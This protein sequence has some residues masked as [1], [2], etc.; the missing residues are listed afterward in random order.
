MIKNLLTNWKTTSAGLTI[1]IAGTVHL[2]FAIHSH[3][4][5]ETDCTTTLVSLVTGVG[6]LAAGDAGVKPPPSGT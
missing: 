2:G 4:L 1:I 3:S 6:L 5:T